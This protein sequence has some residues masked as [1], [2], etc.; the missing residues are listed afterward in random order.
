MCC[1]SA[2]WSTIDFSSFEVLYPEDAQ[3]R[4]N[5]QNREKKECPSKIVHFQR[6]ISGENSQK[7]LL[8]G[9]IVTKRT[10][11]PI[12][13]FQFSVERS[14]LRVVFKDLQNQTCFDQELFHVSQE[15]R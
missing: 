14:F 15:E 2:T 5:S 9:Q 8:L 4:R 1:L 3:F 10:D 12:N 11:V 7:T 6:N 13:D